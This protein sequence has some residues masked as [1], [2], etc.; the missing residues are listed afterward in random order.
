MMSED[1]RLKSKVWT[2]TQIKTSPAVVHPVDGSPVLTSDL[3][4]T[5]CVPRV[6]DWRLP[7]GDT[8]ERGAD[9]GDDGVMLGMW[10]RRLMLGLGFTAAAAKRD[11]RRKLEPQECSV[12][13]WRGELSHSD[14]TESFICCCLQS[15]HDK[16]LVTPVTALQRFNTDGGSSELL[17]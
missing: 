16:P 2:K 17:I 12:A 9:S 1:T 8:P 11:V 4:R 14:T 7:G 3:L 6:K 5:N 15:Q 13:A 10:R